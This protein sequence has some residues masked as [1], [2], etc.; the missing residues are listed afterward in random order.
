MLK[1]NN[2]PESSEFKNFVYNTYQL[3]YWNIFYETCAHRDMIM[4]LQH[5]NL[6]HKIQQYI[7][8]IIIY[9]IC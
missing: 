9:G 7:F 2:V 4:V 6:W 3:D 8:D 1:A 5:C